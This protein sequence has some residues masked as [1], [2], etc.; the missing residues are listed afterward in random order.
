MKGRIILCTILALMIYAITG[1]WIL[2]VIGICAYIATALII[3]ERK[4]YYSDQI[5]QDNDEQK[6]EEEER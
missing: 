1:D 5:E 4:L 2:M 6:E 3:M